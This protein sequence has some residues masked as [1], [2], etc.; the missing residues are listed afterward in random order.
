MCFFFFRPIRAFERELLGY[1]QPPYI[2]PAPS[3]CPENGLAHSRE[4]SPYVRSTSSILRQAR[5]CLKRMALA[6]QKKMNRKMESQGVRRPKP[7]L[8]NSYKE[9]QTLCADSVESDFLGRHLPFKQKSKFMTAK[10][11]KESSKKRITQREFL[12][13]GQD[14]LVCGMQDE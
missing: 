3:P 5:R 4:T 8:Y 7:D 6:Q 2:T 11:L 14:I 13:K 10:Y 9:L 1:S 12:P